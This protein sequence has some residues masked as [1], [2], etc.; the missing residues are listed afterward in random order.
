[1]NRK[2]ILIA[3]AATAL[4]L[5]AG[6][7]GGGSAGISIQLTNAPGTLT[8]NQSV[9]LTATVSNDTANG[10]VDWTCSPSNSCGTFNPTHTANG[11]TTV[12]T[13][14]ST[15]GTV[16]I[17]A[18]AT[19]HS[20]STVSATISIV[21][22]GTNSSLSGN[23]VFFVSGTDSVG[24]Y[25]ATGTIV[26]DGNGNI[27]GGE[28]DYV[29]PQTEAGPDT[30]SGTYSIGTNGTGSITL[31][32][33]D[34]TLPNNGVETFSVAVTSSTHGLIIE[35]D[36]AATSSGTLDFQSAS[37]TDASSIAGSFAFA[38][39]GEDVENSDPA[40]WAGVA[41]LNA[42]SGGITSGQFYGND[43]GTPE[44][45]TIGFSP[46]TGPDQFGRGT[47]QL[48]VGLHFV[49][50]AVQGEVLRTVEEDVPDF[51]TGGAFYGQGA[52]GA[53]SSFSNGSLSGT[54][55]FFDSGS[56]SVGP[57][58]IVGQ[59]TANGSGSLSAGYADTND[60][61]SHAA[62]S[63]SGSPYSIAGNGTGTLTLPGTP[64]TTEDVSALMVFATDPGLNL[65]DPN[66]TAGGGGALI[67][68]TDAGAVGAG[69]LVPQTTGSFQGNYATNLQ[70]FNSAGEEDFVGQEVANGSGGLSGTVDLNDNGTTAPATTF[71]GTYSADTTNTGRYTGTFT[72]GAN[73]YNITYYQVSPTELFILDTDGND[74]GNGFMETE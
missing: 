1:M 50:Y 60:D 13:A 44:N 22:V 18:D 65:Y 24:T 48:S 35:F 53:N 14:P 49:F 64:S 9:S 39:N 37:A 19:D 33:S 68:D 72:V 29:D 20:S 74:V 2:S 38:M 52:N 26:A 42:A 31:N 41:N 28:Q 25:V 71:T 12:Y 4:V 6:C 59:F 70:F 55:V 17:S 5:L 23:Y 7:G 69:Y 63:I 56:T 47:M 62:G 8:V 11:G 67:L 15:A 73:S 57:I 36:G 21:P 27:T 16:T 40:A 10:G 51:V 3:L 30:V 54:Y 61:G 32:V 45:S 46:I 34:I 66:N 43:G 58:S